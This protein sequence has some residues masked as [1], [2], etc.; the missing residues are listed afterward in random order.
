MPAPVSIKGIPLKRKLTQIERGS[1]SI[2]GTL[3]EMKKMKNNMQIVNI[4]NF[5]RGV[6]PRDNEIDLL[7]TVKKQLAFITHYELPA[8]FLLQYDALI[9][10]KFVELL[11]P[12]MDKNIEIGLWLEIVQPL[13]EKAGIEWHGRE[14]FSWDWHSNI[15][16]SVGYTVNERERLVDTAME[17]FRKIFGFFPESVGSWIID[18]HTLLYLKNKYDIKASCNCKDQ[19]GTDGY[20]FWGGYY[21]QAYYPSKKN[22][23]APAQTRDMQIDVPVFRMLGSD[24][25]EQYDAGL[26]DTGS[27]EPSDIQPVITL[28]PAYKYG[29]GS[30]EWVNWFFDVIFRKDC[31][32]FGYTQVGQENSFGWKAMKVGFEYQVE[33]VAK[34]AAEGKIKALTLAAAG[35]WYTENYEL[36]PAAS[37]VADRNLTNEKSSIWYYNRF[38][39]SN[40]FVHDNVPRIRDIFLFH[41][42]YEE[43]YLNTIC[44]VK[45]M[46]YDNLPV[47]DGNRWSFDGK[48]AGIN[49]VALVENQ[50]KPIKLSGKIDTKEIDKDTIEITA[51]LADG[52]KMFISYCLDYMEISIDGQANW[53]LEYETNEGHNTTEISFECNVIHYKHNGFEYKVEIIDGKMSNIGNTKIIIPNESNIKLLFRGKSVDEV[54][55]KSL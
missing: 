35:K 4:I 37:I 47:I 53:A 19:W 21:N 6:E 18:A 23:F 41:Q 54:T 52:G 2:Y 49:F 31:L 24:P 33:Y 12:A 11:K 38:Y 48:R 51:T 7:G 36:T 25:V 14:G 28:E 44:A 29:G 3:M 26:N 32:S 15:G 30:K 46:V 55:K 20:T 17:E 13:V 34:A 9:Q 1:E 16:F 43:R 50:I 42:N 5:V 8:T 39:R 10:N 27:L 40:F 22:V 45:D